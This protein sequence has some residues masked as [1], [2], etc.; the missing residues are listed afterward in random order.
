MI[1]SGKTLPALGRDRSVVLSDEGAHTA[2]KR[3]IVG[4]RPP[5]SN[6]TRVHSLIKGRSQ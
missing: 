6:D 2:Q 5:Y 1:G 3:K 4:Q